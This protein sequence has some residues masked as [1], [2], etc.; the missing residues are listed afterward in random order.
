M[1]GPPRVLSERPLYIA[2]SKFGTVSHLFVGRHLGARYLGEQYDIITYSR[3]VHRRWP[4][5]STRAYL[6]RRNISILSEKETYVRA[7]TWAQ[8]LS[9]AAITFCAC[10]C[11]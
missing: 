9:S 10:E 2:K 7:Y 8:C 1:G 5:V 4:R 11:L 6:S 3:G